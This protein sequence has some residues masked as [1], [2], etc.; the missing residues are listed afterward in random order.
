[1][2]SRARGPARVQAAGERP[3][4]TAT[5]T[6]APHDELIS[7]GPCRLIPTNWGSVSGA[8]EQ[9]GE[10]HQKYAGTA[11]T[12]QSV[13]LI[14]RYLSETRRNATQAQALRFKRC[15]FGAVIRQVP[16][17]KRGMAAVFASLTWMS[18]PTRRKQKNRAHGAVL[19]SQCPRSGSQ[20]LAALHC[21]RHESGE[22]AQPQ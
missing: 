7:S 6:L 13:R 8:G 16:A 12:N 21:T 22:Q 19:R 5:R 18:K 20:G 11:L 10:R 1:M 3:A 14:F 4:E 15:G 9:M 17:F 2:E